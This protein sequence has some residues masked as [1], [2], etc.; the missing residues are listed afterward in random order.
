VELEFGKC[1]FLWKEENPWRK[2]ENQ[3]LNPHTTP[4]PGIETQATLVEG[5][6]SH[7]R[8]IP[9]YFVLKTQNKHE[10]FF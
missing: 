8:A 7:H 3:Q 6:C 1:W 2:D 10:H 9:A 4:G 5:E